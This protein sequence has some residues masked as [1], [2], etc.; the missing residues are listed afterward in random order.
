MIF[1]LKLRM[2]RQQPVGGRA[3]LT[4]GLE[5]RAVVLAQDLQPCAEVIGMAHGRRTVGTMPSAAQRKAEP[6]SATSSSRA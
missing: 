3:G 2:A 6:I 1:C 4:G 5:D